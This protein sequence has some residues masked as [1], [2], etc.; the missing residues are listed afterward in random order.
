[1][2]LHTNDKTEPS[3][4]YIAFELSNSKWRLE[5][6]D[7]VKRR[8]RVI[9]ALDLQSLKSEISHAKERFGFTCEDVQILSCYEAGRDGF[10][11]HRYLESEGIKNH[12]VDSSSIEVSRRSRNA[13]TDRI[14]ARKLMNKLLSYLRGESHL[15]VVRVPSEETEDL[16]NLHREEQRLKK[17]RVRISNKLRSHFARMGTRLG[18]LGVK[19]SR[20]QSELASQ[21][22]LTGKVF[23]DY[24]R[25]ELERLYEQYMLVLEHLKLIEKHKQELL[26]TSQDEA[27]EKVRR[28]MELKGIGVTSAWLFVMEF[29]GWRR[30]RNRREVGAL[31]GLVNSP[32]SS[33]DSHSD[34]GISK[35]GN[36]RVRAMVTE[37]AWKWLELQPHS[38]T[39]QWFKERYA[40]GSKRMRRVGIVAV[41]RRLLIV[42]WRYL[43]TGVLEE[44]MELKQA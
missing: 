29:Y 44:G 28:L 9:E 37:I 39:S 23:P 33:G 27:I 19:R 1:M 35:A 15:S 40:P 5:F 2:A 31:A 32:H 30:F 7:G 17:E 42:L 8:Q 43:E 25:Q 11:L 10:Y 12:V 41:C 26:E 16:R 13:K 24:V 4:L 36:K 21:R 6:S 3:T 14:E 34:Q 38:R 22:T 20:W 18:Y